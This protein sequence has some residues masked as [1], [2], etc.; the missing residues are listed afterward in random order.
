M[1]NPDTLVSIHGYVGDAA[2]IKTFLPYYLHHQ[3]PVLILSPTDSP[4]TSAEV[5]SRPT[6]KYQTGGLRAYV[7]QV[8][9]DRQIEHLKILLQQKENY[10]LM[11]DS[12]SVCLSPELPRYLYNE[13]QV[14]WSNV[15][16]D[17]MHPRDPEYPFPRLAFQPPYFCHR[18][19][20]EKL[21]TVADTVKGNP[22]TPFIDWCMMAWAVS[23]G[24]PYKTFPDGMSCPTN[25][26]N[27]EAVRCMREGV[28]IHGK[29]FLH[30]IKTREMML[31]VGNDR[32]AF[33]RRH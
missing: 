14:L 11:H 5:P 21:L 30:S 31:A 9:L 28:G 3:T 13:P 26:D 4:I 27:R 15:V 20:V 18:S 17:E 6:I 16:S 12:D 25:A 22:R 23:A 10:F 1:L 33:K 8:S 7:G 19:V 29:I 24:V 32:V 2:Q